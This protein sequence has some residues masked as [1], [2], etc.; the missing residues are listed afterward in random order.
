MTAPKAKATATKAKD[1][2][3]EESVEPSTPSTPLTQSEIELE[4]KIYILI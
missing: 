3:S 2:K 4:E 1:V